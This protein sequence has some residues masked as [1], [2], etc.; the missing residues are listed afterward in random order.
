[1]FWIGALTYEAH[2][3]PKPRPSWQ[4]QGVLW[5]RTLL[6][7]NG[8]AEWGLLC[9]PLGVFGASAAAGA[10]CWAQE[11]LAVS[12]CYW[13]VIYLGKKSFLNV[14]P[15]CIFFPSHCWS[16]SLSHYFETKLWIV[17]SSLIPKWDSRL[18]F[19]FFKKFTFS[20]RLSG[21][22]FKHLLKAVKKSWEWNDHSTLTR[23][24]I[25]KK[26]VIK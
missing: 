14:N 23:A 4:R 16:Q 8:L 6:P 19:T 22:N 1:M 17:H 11:V 21:R 25:F 9:C 2:E 12:F 18:L 20:L 15:S 3:Y 5:S 26:L 7:P 13:T 24:I 10:L